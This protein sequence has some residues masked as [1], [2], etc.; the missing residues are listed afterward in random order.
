MSKIINPS[1][2]AMQTADSELSNALAALHA[3]ASGTAVAAFRTCL[4]AIA[5]RLQSEPQA[6]QDSLA[7][8]WRWLDQEGY[9]REPFAAT[10]Q[11]ICS[12]SL[13]QQDWLALQAARD[14]AMGSEDGLETL[15]DHLQSRHPDLTVQ[16]ERLE[17]MAFDEQQALEATAAGK[18][19]KKDILIGVGVYAGYN[20][21]GGGLI[22]FILHRRG[23]TEPVRQLLAMDVEKRVAAADQLL[24]VAKHDEVEAMHTVTQD[25]RRQLREVKILAPDAMAQGTENLY[26]KYSP[27]IN[28]GFKNLVFPDGVTPLP[29]CN[30]ANKGEQYIVNY[31]ER[32]MVK[33]L[34]DGEI[35]HFYR[36]SG[37]AQKDPEVWPVKSWFPVNGIG[38]DGWINKTKI[39]AKLG[40]Q[41]EKIRKV[42]ELLL[43]KHEESIINRNQVGERIYL[44]LENDQLFIESVN[45][46]LKDIV[47]NDGNNLT[48][49]ELLRKAFSQI[50]KERNP[51]AYYVLKKE[52]KLNSFIKK[53]VWDPVK[54]DKLGASWPINNPEI[55]N[56]E[57]ANI[58]RTEKVKAT[59]ASSKKII[60]RSKALEI[61]R[62]RFNVPATNLE[63]DLIEIENAAETRLRDLEIQ[64]QAYGYEKFKSDSK[65]ILDTKKIMNN[66]DAKLKTIEQDWANRIIKAQGSKLTSSLQKF[67]DKELTSAIDQADSRAKASVIEEE[68]NAKGLIVRE[69]IRVESAIASDEI[70]LKRSLLDGEGFM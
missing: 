64:A 28:E 57:L 66:A 1:Q 7:H 30:I 68:G 5:L 46:G 56:Q 53:N 2:M 24:A 58:I 40:S 13:S 14:Q 29:I 31:N 9:D 67:V 38:P 55:S 50:I 52:H 8:W 39:S 22:A 44:D 62:A 54:R 65:V 16:L 27:E 47:A 48:D 12:S 35:Y 18:I 3:D 11:Q 63:A 4:C 26:Q 61:Y 6:A 36:S 45:K 41:S 69:E 10:L 15:I 19:T 21:L 70:E 20:I 60:E 49:K 51:K 33:F 34:I 43:L 17:A 32:D 42:Q 37:L 59:I 23:K 25:L